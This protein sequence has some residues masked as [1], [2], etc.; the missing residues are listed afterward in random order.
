[1]S[2]VHIDNVDQDAV[3]KT[4]GLNPGDAN[5]QAVLLICQRYH[6]DPLLKHVVLIQGR[7]YITRDGLITWAHESGQ[8]DGIEIVDEGETP[9]HWWA[10]CAVYRKDMSRPFTYKGR[11]PKKGGNTAYGPEMAIK[12]AEVMA[13]RRAFNVTGLP[14]AEEAWDMDMTAAAAK[15]RLLAAAGGDKAAAA[16]AWDNAGLSGRQRVGEDELVAAINSLDV[17]DIDIDL[18]PD[19]ELPAV[20]ADGV[21]DT[22]TTGEPGECAPGSPCGHCDMCQA[23]P[24]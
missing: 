18:V 8:F 17:L 3:L 19:L 24:G 16:A 5:T 10:R 1:M 4:L 20:D 14:A 21:I 6:L 11:Y 23:E 7:P 12:C 13:L 9:S 2:L 22:T 15:N